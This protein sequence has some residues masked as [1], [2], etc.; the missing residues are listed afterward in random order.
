[1][2]PQ[3]SHQG[4]PVTF[5][6]RG[7]PPSLR[8]GR[9][10]ALVSLCTFRR[11]SCT[12]PWRRPS[13]GPWPF[14][15]ASCQPAS[16]SC[17]TPCSPSCFWNSFA[18]TLASR[19]HPDVASEWPGHAQRPPPQ[20]LRRPG[21]GGQARPEPRTCRCAPAPPPSLPGG[22]ETI[23]PSRAASFTSSRCLPGVQQLLLCTV[24]PPR[25]GVSTSRGF[26]VPKEAVNPGAGEGL[27]PASSP[28]P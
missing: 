6:G 19:C 14:T 15:R 23:H 28:S 1:M 3:L 11:G 22:P 18:N 10:P 25:R 13:S 9:G 21:G 24:T 17:P 27:G 16:A 4:F 20:F 8:R 2:C 12:A 26:F 5:P 7:G